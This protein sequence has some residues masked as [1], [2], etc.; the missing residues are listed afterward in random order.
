M[1]N[2]KLLYGILIITVLA[3]VGISLLY[4]SKPSI[5]DLKARHGMD[6]C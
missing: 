2:K 1:K 5:E 3:I 6:H 4:M